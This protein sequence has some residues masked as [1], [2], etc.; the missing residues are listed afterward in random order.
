MT[1]AEPEKQENIDAYN[2]WAAEHEHILSKS[3]F[4]GGTTWP[5]VFFAEDQVRL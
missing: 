5:G 4:C 3:L 1:D 2:Q